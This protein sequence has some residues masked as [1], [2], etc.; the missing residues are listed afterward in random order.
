MKRMRS[1]LWIAW[2]APAMSA[3]AAESAHDLAAAMRAALYAEGF[4]ARIQA[5]AV[6]PDGGRATPVK[7]AVVGQADAARQRLLLRG[8]A[9]EATQA[10][11]L[12]V[13]RSADGCVRAVAPAGA[14]DPHVPLFDTQLV[15]WDMLAPWWDWPRQTLA[16]SDQV[17]GRPCALV[18]SRTDAAD[19]PIREV[20]SCVDRAAGLA[21]RTQLFDQR[22]ALVRSIVV[23][24]TLRQESGQL[25]AK[26]F[27]VAAGDALTEAEVY[28]GDEHYAVPADAFAPLDRQ[29]TP[30]R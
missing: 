12:V 13:E 27:T 11:R 26:K 28:S 2:L 10:R 16:G 20:L 7:F 4:E 30:C 14:A 6:A 23:A 19:A 8:I 3:A 1:L 18:R 9:P 22:H 17:A 5:V 25:A 15:A 29:P 24:T 21:L